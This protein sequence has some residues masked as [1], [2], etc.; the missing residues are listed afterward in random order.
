MKKILVAVIICVFATVVVSAFEGRKALLE[1]RITVMLQE[2][3]PYVWGK[4]DCSG[5]MWKIL[6]EIFPEYR[7]H[8]WFNRTTAELMSIWP[9]KIVIDKDDLDFGDLIFVNSDKRIPI[10]CATHINH[11]MMGWTDPLYAVH[12]SSSKGFSKTFIPG[13]WVDR[14]IKI[15]RPPY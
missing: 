11:I 14:I 6:R 1:A 5:Q 2:N 10:N 13:Y 15:T 4:S 3:E 9:Y 12:A 8:K 7:A